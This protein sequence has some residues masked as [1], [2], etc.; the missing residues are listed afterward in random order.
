MRI[1]FEGPVQGHPDRSLAV[2]S[3]QC[4]I[5]IQRGLTLP[6]S[7]SNEHCCQPADLEG[8]LQGRTLVTG[9]KPHL[10]HGLRRPDTARETIHRQKGMLEQA[11]CR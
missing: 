10:Q 6:V 4:C 2:R 11:T 9:L 7:L 3:D 1:G 8:V 5:L